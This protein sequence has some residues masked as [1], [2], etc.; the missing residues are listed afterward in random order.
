MLN[1]KLTLQCKLHTHWTLCR[2]EIVAGPSLRYQ[3]KV[4][5][6]QYR[7]RTHWHRRASCG[8]DAA[9]TSVAQGQFNH[10]LHCLLRTL[11][12]AAEEAELVTAGCGRSQHVSPRQPDD[13]HSCT[14]ANSHQRPQNPAHT[15]PHLAH[16]PRCT[17]CCHRCSCRSAHA[18]LC[19]LRHLHPQLLA[20]NARTFWERTPACFTPTAPLG[21]C[22]SP[23]RATLAPPPPDRLFSQHSPRQ[24]V[25][26]SPE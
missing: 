18:R 16:Q 25:P 3:G 15:T 12:C 22:R 13:A 21:C 6:V 4:Q 8:L 7:Q 9:Y 24:H 17:T 1:R 14:A 10:R 26:L 11:L 5:A 19:S 2:D 23:Q 20:T